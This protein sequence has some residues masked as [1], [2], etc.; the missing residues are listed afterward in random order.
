MDSL[1]QIAFAFRT[2]SQNENNDVRL[3]YNEAGHD[4]FK[5]YILLYANVFDST[6]K[7]KNNNNKKK[8]RKLR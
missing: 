5:H 7:K 2:I 1:K 4:L 3:L 6:K 8:R